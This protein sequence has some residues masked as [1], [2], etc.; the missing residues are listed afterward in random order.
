MHLAWP[1]IHSRDPPASYGLTVKLSPCHSS[2]TGRIA[3]CLCGHTKCNL[4]PAQ[5]H[6]GWFSFFLVGTYQHCWHC[7]LCT[8]QHTGLLSEHNLP[9]ITSQLYFGWMGRVS[10]MKLKL[11]INQG[12]LWKWFLSY[13]QYTVPQNGVLFVTSSPS[14]NFLGTHWIDDVQT[15]LQ[16]VIP[17]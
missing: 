14:C 9:P 16:S 4:L 10:Y 12:I 11:G 6:P 17:L 7:E 8:Q 15:E 5:A 1:L 13:L 2:P 3:A